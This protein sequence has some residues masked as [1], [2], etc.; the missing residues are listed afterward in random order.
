[1]RVECGAAALLPL[2]FLP[3][4]RASSSAAASGDVNENGTADSADADAEW[5]GRMTVTYEDARS[6]EA[7]GGRDL[8]QREHLK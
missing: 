7:R 4:S 8:L 6:P 2:A 5:P 1:M 3:T